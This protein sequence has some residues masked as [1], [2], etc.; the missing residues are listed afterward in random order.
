MATLFS[1]FT[2]TPKKPSP[3][4]GDKAEGIKENK[5]PKNTAKGVSPPKKNDAKSEIAAPCGVSNGR[6]VKPELKQFEIVW[7]KMDGHPSW[8]SIIC[9]HPT[10]LKFIEDNQCHVQFFGDPPSRGWVNVK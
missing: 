9:D 8:P 7:A 1:Y 4:E 10:K 6:V 5:K 2:K 3:S